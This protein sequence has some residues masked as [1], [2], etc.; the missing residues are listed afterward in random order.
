MARDYARIKTSIWNDKDFLALPGDAQRLY[1]LIVEQPE[2]NLCGVIRP[3]FPR[4]S[5]FASDTPLPKIKK[6]AAKLVEKKYLLVDELEDELLI[7][8]FVRHDINLNS[9][10]VIVGLSNAFGTTRSHTLQCTIIHELARA[11][12][13]GL[14]KLL[15]KGLEEG[16]LN[17]LANPF[18]NA[19]ANRLVKP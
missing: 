12:D 7:R 8:T 13:Q 17:R 4:W 15:P 10:N 19:W 1:H 9:P 16:L 2:L 3:A 18:V 6:A 11:K 14:M 5:R